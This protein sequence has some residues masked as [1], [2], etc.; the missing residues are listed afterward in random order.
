MPCLAL[1]RRLNRGMLITEPFDENGYEVLDQGLALFF[2]A[3]HSFTGEN[4]LRDSWSW[5]SGGSGCSD[6]QAVLI[7]GQDWLDRESSVKELFLNDKLDL[8]QAEAIADLI[9]AASS[10]SARSA[11]RSLKGEFSSAYSILS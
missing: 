7:V 3:P 2:P 9:D 1:P 6:T 8:A 10:Q 5:R 11:L 4:V